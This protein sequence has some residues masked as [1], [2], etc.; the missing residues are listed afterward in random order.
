MRAREHRGVSRTCL[1]IVIGSTLIVLLTVLG[2]W[3]NFK[4]RSTLDG[5]YSANG[6]MQLSSG[7]VIDVAHTILFSDG[8]FYAMTKQG[9]AI[10][11]TSGSIEY[12]FL[13]RY[14]LRVEEGNVTGL[15][16]DTDNELVFNLM[17]GRHR[18]S[19]IRLI[20]FRSCL[21]GLETRQVYCAV[22][23]P[24]AL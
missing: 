3:L 6:Q 11:E 5:R 18:G 9:D 17:Y 14:R 7:Q 15:S 8:R 13:R 12:G 22:K 19:S 4:S 16:G 10:L 23:Q 21:Y 2:L 24:T 20:P 1:L